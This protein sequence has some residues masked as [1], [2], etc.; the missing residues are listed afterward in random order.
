M[1]FRS[2]DRHLYDYIGENP[3]R[4]QSKMLNNIAII[5]NVK[6]VDAYL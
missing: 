4:G 1:W 2:V 5:D 6:V 3:P